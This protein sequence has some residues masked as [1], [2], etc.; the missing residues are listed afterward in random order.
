[1]RIVSYS[2]YSTS[3]RKKQ[4]RRLQDWMI[5]LGLYIGGL[6]VMIILAVSLVK[7]FGLQVSV[8][9]DTMEPTLQGEERVLLNRF[10]YRL[11]SPRRLDVVAM[12][13]GSSQSSPTYI[14][15]IIGV[16][17]D[18]VKIRAGKVYIDDKELPLKYN[19][20]RIHYAGAASEGIELKEGEYFVL[21]DDYNGSTDDSRLDSIGMVSSNRLIG[22]VWLVTYPLKRFRLIR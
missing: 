6:L 7:G 21:C 14:R 2:G 13:I 3:P 15:R 12:K 18:T 17:G 16:P 4:K 20:E 8:I 11:G 9:G 10:A 22:K 5:R 19:D 1:M